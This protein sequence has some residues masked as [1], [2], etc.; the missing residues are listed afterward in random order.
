MPSKKELCRTWKLYVIT[1]STCLKDKS[2]LDVVAQV[3][4]AGASVIQLRDKKA[5]DQALIKTA[6]EL[7]KITRPKNVPL[8]IND[9]IQVAIGSGADGIHLGQDDASLSDAQKILG[10]NFIFG[11]STHSREQALQAELEG[12]DYIGVGPVFSTPTKPTYEPVGLELIKFAAKNI[13]IP[14][15]A[16]GGIDASNISQVL[17]MGAK[18]VAV[19][20]AVMAA[21]NPGQATQHLISYFTP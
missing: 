6:K 5:S 10:E 4:E 7:L 18:K 16:I 11:R 1:D 15:V 17:S 9:R 3:V 19:V 14:F 8:I 21:N 12:F 20:R 2:L 13:K